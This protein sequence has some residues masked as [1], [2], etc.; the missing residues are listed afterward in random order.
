MLG[1]GRVRALRQALVRWV[2][3]L[4][5]LLAVGC[6]KKNPRAIPATAAATASVLQP[7]QLSAEPVGSAAGSH[8][9]PPSPAQQEELRD[10]A[11][12]RHLRATSSGNSL[13]CSA[14]RGLGLADGR[15][16]RKAQ[17]VQRANECSP[18]A[19][20][21]VA[22]VETPDG[23]FVPV[24]QPLDPCSYRLWFV[25]RELARQP[26]PASE[27]LEEFDLAFTVRLQADDLDNDKVVEAVLVRGWSHP[28]GVG[29]GQ[30]AYLVE[31]TGEQ[32]PLPFNDLKDIDGDG[33]LDAVVSFT[34]TTNAA[35]CEPPDAFEAWVPSTLYA[36]DIVLHRQAG[37]GF[38]L[39]DEVSRHAR[40]KACKNQGKNP[41]VR[42]AGEI[43]EDETARRAVCQLANGADPKTIER[44]LADACSRN[45]EVPTDCKKRRPGVCFWRSRLLALPAAFVAL[46]PW[47]NVPAAH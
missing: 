39:T 13:N 30:N 12:L 47:L 36:P 19:A 37:L 18:E 26:I 31:P 34:S 45:Y 23:W 21:L 33:L 41:V 27:V 11:E 3:A 25:P 29:D 1:S 16:R 15:A 22:C 46:Q 28:E 2:G 43:D 35:G 14:F 5:T 4:A 40:A 38:S 20:R 32:R 6:A 7:A 9:G 42:R 17:G 24:E 8:S 44:A 10:A